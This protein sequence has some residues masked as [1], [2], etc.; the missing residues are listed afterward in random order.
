MKRAVAVAA[1]AL[2]ACTAAPVALPPQHRA[3]DARTCD[4]HGLD[5]YVGQ[6]ASAALGATLMDR[7]GAQTLRWVPPGSA[8]TMD[9]SPQRLTVSYDEAMRITRLS[10]G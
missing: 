5:A 1:V 7:S 8:V 3:V 6:R 9:F 10:C 2:G 4:A